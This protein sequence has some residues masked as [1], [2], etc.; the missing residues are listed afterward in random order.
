MNCQYNQDQEGSV[1]KMDL[2]EVSFHEISLI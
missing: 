2:K 1:L